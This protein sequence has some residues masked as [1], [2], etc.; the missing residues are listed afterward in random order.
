MAATDCR[1]AIGSS[2]KP[3]RRNGTTAALGIADGWP[4]I[5]TDG[6]NSGK[7]RPM[8]ARLNS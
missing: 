4:S 7:Q 5:A 2:L 6:D 1:V 8:G 3:V